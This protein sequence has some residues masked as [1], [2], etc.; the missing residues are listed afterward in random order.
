MPFTWRAEEE[1]EDDGEE[2]TAEA[3][4]E[5]VQEVGDIERGNE[6]T[7]DEPG[8]DKRL[9]EDGTPECGGAMNEFQKEGD[10]KQ[11]EDHA[12]EKRADD[13][14]GLD[15][16]FLEVGEEEEGEDHGEDAPGDGDEF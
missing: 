11:A 2:N 3:A 1:L 15:E 4:D 12:G 7:G 16:I 10:E 8:D 9:G 14:C 5:V 6:V 13:V